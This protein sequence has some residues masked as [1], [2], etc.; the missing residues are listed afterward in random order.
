MTPLRIAINTPMI[1]KK[2]ISAAVSVLRSGALTSS[3]R[4]GGT[5]VQDFEKAAASFTGSRYAVAVNSGTAALQAALHALDVGPG[6]E[7]LVPSFTFVATANAVASTGATPVFVDIANGEYTVDVEDLR[8]KITKKTRAIIPV[9]L[10][11]HVADVEGLS[12][13]SARYCIPVIEDSAQ[14]L[15][16]TY[17]GRHAGTFFEMGCYSMYPAKVMTSGEGGFV[18]TGSRR[19]RDRL[20]MIRNHGMVRGYDTRIPGLNMRLPEISAAIATVQMKRL[21]GFLKSRR[22]NAKLLSG[23][24]SDLK[25]TPP[26]QQKDQDVNWYLYTIAVRGRN[27]LLRRLNDAGIGAASYYPTPVHRT[28]LYR[29]DVRLPNTERA[30]SRVLSLPVHPQVTTRDIRFIAETLREAL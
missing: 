13:I 20:L 16:S 9:H 6:D 4:E 27:R 24:I 26:C 23:M 22:R 10:Y 5:H 25:V 29:S 1:G 18:V 3:A 14:A 12:E 17:K 15:G 21:P 19:L 28:P 2:E 11:G 30:A 7:V 8:A